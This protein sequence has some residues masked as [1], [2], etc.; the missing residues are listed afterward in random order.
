MKR[1]AL[2]ATLCGAIAGLVGGGCAP[3]GPLPGEGTTAFVGATLF[4]GRGVIDSAVMLVRDGK[5]VATGGTADVEVPPG[6]ERVDVSGRFITPGLVLGH[7]HVGASKGLETGPGVYT[8]ENLRAQLALYARYGVTTVVSLGGDGPEAILLRDQQDT[9]DLDRS[10]IFVAGKIIDA[11]TPEDARLMVDDDA[12]MGVNIIKIRVDDNLGTTQKMP[13]AVY[14]AVIDQAH[15]HN[16]PVAVHLYYL[17]DAKAALNAGADFIAHSVRDKEVDQEL[18]DLLKSK[19]V[20]LCPTLVREVSTYVYESV[21]EFF[22]DPFFLREADPKVL[23]QLKD[24][25]RQ[26]AVQKSKAAQQ[27][28]K[29]LQV[30]SMNLKKLS[31]AGVRIAFGTDT[32]PPARFQGYF[33]HME[34]QLMAKAGLTPEQILRS[35]TS[36]VARCL[37][38]PGVGTLEAGKWADFDV[39]AKNPLQDVAN[40]ETLES[41]WIAGNRVPDKAPPETTN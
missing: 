17:D 25:E 28:K 39:F 35:A 5:V 40:S 30:A 18:I 13:P 33:E 34:L 20:C 11:D 24:P 38:L 8:E 27:Y 41:V 7:G 1:F 3:A 22:S 4:D 29:G 6:A 32:G 9:A 36:E 21:P 2:L 15:K 23:E 31:D 19:N 26:A 37:K 16:L 10:R 12:R 14:Q